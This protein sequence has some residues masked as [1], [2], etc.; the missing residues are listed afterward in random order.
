M[1]VMK[2]LEGA[3]ALIFKST[4]FPGQ[5]VACKCGSPLILGIKEQADEKETALK[6]KSSHHAHSPRR[7]DDRPVEYFLASDASAVVEHTK[8]VVVMEDDDVV[9]IDRGNYHMYRV[10]HAATQG[11]SLRSVGREVQTLDME[12]EQIM[13]GQ[14]DHFMQKEIYEQPESIMGTLRGRVKFFPETDIATLVKDA[15]QGKLVDAFGTIHLGGLEFQI[16]FSRTSANGKDT[17]DACRQTSATLATG[18][19]DGIPV[20]TVAV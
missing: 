10:D 3:Y 13:K 4:H 5:L 15:E 8:S 9:H 11:L 16:Q 1:E 14:Y 2:H 12:V 19:A 6:L 7:L 20:M 17:S 18:S